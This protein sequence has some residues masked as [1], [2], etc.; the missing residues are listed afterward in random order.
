M[1]GTFIPAGNRSLW[2][3]VHEGATHGNDEVDEEGHPQEVAFST[4]ANIAALLRGSTRFENTY[5]AAMAQNMSIAQLTRGFV[6]EE[7]VPPSRFVD[8]TTEQS[9]AVHWNNGLAF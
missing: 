3:D 1:I 7:I 4:K 5:A 8:M 2:S 6:Y 9:K